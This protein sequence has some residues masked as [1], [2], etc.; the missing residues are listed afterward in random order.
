MAP[1]NRY[2]LDVVAGADYQGFSILVSLE[3]NNYGKGAKFSFKSLC[4]K[5]IRRFIKT[6]ALEVNLTQKQSTN[7]MIPLCFLFRQCL[8]SVYCCNAWLHPVSAVNRTFDLLVERLMIDPLYHS[9]SLEVLIWFAVLD[10]LE[11]SHGHSILAKGLF[12]VTDK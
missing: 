3:N 9:H 5:K 8:W 6:E 4:W 7:S 11:A 10:R 1:H 12:E 2:P